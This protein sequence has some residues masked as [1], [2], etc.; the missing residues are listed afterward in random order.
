VYNSRHGRKSKQARQGV[1]IGTTEPSGVAIRDQLEGSALYGPLQ[2]AYE[3]VSLTGAT[4][5]RAVTHPREW[6]RPAIVEASTYFRRC[7]LPLMISNGIWLWG[8]GVILF[9]ALAQHLGVIDREGGGVDVGFTREVATWITMMILAGVAGSAMAADLGARK[10]REELDALAVL[11]VDKLRLLVVPRMM[12]MIFVAVTLPLIDL[13]ETD[14]IE[15]LLV[16][17]HSHVSHTAFLSTLWQNIYPLDLFS[18]AL[19]HLVMGIFIGAVACQKGLSAKGGAEGV[20]RAVNQT[21][22]LSFLGIWVINSIFNTAYL[23]LFP[24]VIVAKG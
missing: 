24:Q 17:G 21:V 1:V 2:T 16:P 4:L 20:G 22:V 9:G 7:M 13:L 11:G 19:K 18:A 6:I 10:T 12:A 23:T 3:L 5:K 14:V 8:F 15:F